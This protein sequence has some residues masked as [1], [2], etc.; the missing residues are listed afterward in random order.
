MRPFQP[1]VVFSLLFVVYEAVSADYEPITQKKKLDKLYVTNDYLNISLN[2]YFEGYNLSYDV[3]VEEGG[4][5]G[6]NVTVQQV[7][8]HR[9]IS[10][11]MPKFYINKILPSFDQKSIFIFYNFPLIQISR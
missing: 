3:T 7:A 4:E 8:N 5:V 11:P 6:N 10:D 9:N 2:E 1:L